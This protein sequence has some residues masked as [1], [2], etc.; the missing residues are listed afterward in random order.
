MNC[1]PAELERI[2]VGFMNTA[3]VIRMRIVNKSFREACKWHTPPANYIKGRIRYLKASF[4]YATELKLGCRMYLDD[5]FLNLDH[6]HKLEFQI[7]TKTIHSRYFRHLTELVYLDIRHCDIIAFQ[8]DTFRYLTKLTHFSIADNRNITD[9]GLSLL[10]NLKHLYIHNV[11]RITDKGLST[12]KS[13]T[14][15]DMYNLRTVTD[16]VTEHLPEL[17]TLKMTMGTLTMKGICKLKNLTH[18]DVTSSPFTTTQGMET[19]PSLVRVSFTCCALQDEDLEYFGHVKKLFLYGSRIS[20]NGFR[21]LTSVNWLA[22]HKMNL[23]L[24]Y[25]DQLI[26]LPL[27]QNIAMYECSVPKETKLLLKEKMPTI[28][29]SD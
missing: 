11:E 4:P 24:E 16:D 14:F 26:H 3:K 9:Q 28:F 13:L 5:D 25:I 22:L 15:L 21:H 23:K 20:G 10:S 1:L 27:I 8:D 12:M 2:V 29:H 18:L 6:V 19:L 7:F 17:R